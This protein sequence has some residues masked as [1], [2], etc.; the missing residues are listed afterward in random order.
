MFVYSQQ[1]PC[2]QL[3]IKCVKTEIKIDSVENLLVDYTVTNC[4]KSNLIINKNEVV[5]YEDS[6]ENVYFDLYRFVDGGNVLNQFSR[7]DIGYI[8][9]PEKVV[10][11]PN[12]SYT[13]KLK[14]FNTYHIYS[15]GEYKLIAYYRL[16]LVSNPGFYITKSNSLDFIIK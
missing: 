6:G 4:G 2:I 8:S 3:S 9:Y 14:V 12:K 7:N 15:P 5:D 11:K 1:Y 13:Y 10:L 16:K